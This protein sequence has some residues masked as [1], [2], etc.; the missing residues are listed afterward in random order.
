MAESYFWKVN[1]GFV[2]SRESELRGFDHS[3]EILN[4]SLLL[5][6]VADSYAFSKSG[7][8][9]LISFSKMWQPAKLMKD[10]TRLHKA[11]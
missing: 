3:S 4:F 10:S 8:A 9:D 2:F 7:N 1:T 5:V 11:H 6:S